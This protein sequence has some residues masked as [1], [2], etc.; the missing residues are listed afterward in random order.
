MQ[1][2]ISDGT[3]LKPGTYTFTASGGAD[4]GPVTASVNFPE[5]FTWTND[6]S[7]TSIDRTQPLP[8]TWSGGT[9]GGLVVMSGESDNEDGT[10]AS[11]ECFADATAGAFTIPSYVLLALPPSISI[12][13][14][15]GGT[16]EVFQ[17]VIG[18]T[19]SAKGLDYGLMETYIGTS[20]SG[21]TYK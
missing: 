3:R 2:I 15:A 21:V 6:A 16:L 8:I 5:A 20:K 13:G 4:V 17:F 19:F 7:I 9:A 18:N 14:V 12:G 1:Q 10:G 11:F